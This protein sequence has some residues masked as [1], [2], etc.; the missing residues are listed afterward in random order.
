MFTPIG[1]FATA[2]AGGTPF[3]D[4]LLAQYDATETSTIT[5]SGTDVTSWAPIVNYDSFPNLEPATAAYPQY[6]SSIAVDFPASSNIFLQGS[7]SA[8]T[9]NRNNGGGYGTV[10]VAYWDVPMVHP[11]TFKGQVVQMFQTTGGRFPSE[12]IFINEGGSNNN[13]Q[14]D[15]WVD[16]VVVGASDRYTSY[17]PGYNIIVTSYDKDNGFK[18]WNNNT[19][20]MNNTTNFPSTGWVGGGINILSVMSDYRTSI[21]FLK[22]G[23]RMYELLFWNKVSSDADATEIYNYLY[24]KHFV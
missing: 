20:T 16:G 14:V 22:V 19:L 17:S 4:D 13:Y 23:G 18:S 21:S 9:G 8:V 12:Q 24:N 1:F 7:T 10:A 6:T 3:S 2:A 5:L 15:R 11:P